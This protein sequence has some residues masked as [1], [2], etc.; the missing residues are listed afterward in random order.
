ML[1]VFL[2]EIKYHWEQNLN[3][4]TPDLYSLKTVAALLIFSG[5]ILA[6]LLLASFF[7]AVSAFSLIVPT[8]L[9]IG[10]VII[11][12]CGVFWFFFS[13][14]TTLS[15]IKRREIM[16]FMETRNIWLKYFLPVGRSVSKRIGLDPDKFVR[17][18]VQLNNEFILNIK[19]SKPITNIMILLPHCIQLHSCGMKLTSDIR[20]CKQCGKCVV[21]EL[22][23]LSDGL[24][25]EMFIASGGTMARRQIVLKKP[26]L[27]LA[28]AC[29]R[30]LISGIRDVIP[31]KVLGIL[32]KRPEGPC[33]NTTVDAAQIAE[34]IRNL[35]K[36]S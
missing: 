34:L 2:Q 27:I 16:P 35:K 10:L 15:I 25:V 28:V 19:K 20:N 13:L 23:E 18:C 30:D 29:E 14:I 7:V 22:I 17:S 24:E 12:I 32:N 6:C 33:R 5:F 4:D 3:N 36:A 8:F 1:P 21:G 31:L 26:D 9:K 11:G